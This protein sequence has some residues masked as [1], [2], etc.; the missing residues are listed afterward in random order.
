MTRA[1]IHAGDSVIVGTYEGGAYIDLH[2]DSASAPAFDVINVWDYRADAPT[3]PNTSAA[4]KAEMIEWR[5]EAGDSL[6]HDLVNY[7]ESIR[8]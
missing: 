6:A 1:T 8:Y 2:F 7:R 3:I 5:D 4:V